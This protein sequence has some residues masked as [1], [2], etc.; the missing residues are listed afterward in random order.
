MPKT[1]P[2]TDPKV[3]AWYAASDPHSGAL[4]ALRALLVAAGLDEV[5]K[6]RSPC[7]T[8]AD[9][10]IATVWS[11]KDRAAVGFFKGSL[12]DDPGGLLQAPG[13]NSRAMRVLNVTGAAQVAAHAPAIRD[14]LAQALAVEAAGQKVDFAAGETPIPPE[15]T[16]ALDTDPDLAAAWAGL[17][18]GRRRGWLLQI[19]QAKQ[20]ATRRGRI[21]KARPLIL[22]GK[23]PQDR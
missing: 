5:F 4:P 1:D 3:E 7:Y 15:M 17:T 19:A 18:P 10:N 20:A 14:F 21:G 23:G 12:L 8:Q 2:M 6:W 22:A 13:E 16:D 11:F 9:A